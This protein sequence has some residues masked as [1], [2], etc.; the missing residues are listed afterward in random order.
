VSRPSTRRARGGAPRGPSR[1]T[2]S[3]RRPQRRPGHPVRAIILS[4]A[5]PDDTDRRATYRLA[6]G[7][8]RNF[9]VVPKPARRD[10]WRCPSVTNVEHI[11]SLR[12][13]AVTRPA[14]SK[15]RRVRRRPP[16][17]W[18][19]NL[20]YATPW[21]TGHRTE[22]GDRP[23]ARVGHAGESLTPGNVARQ[24]PGTEGPRVRTKQRRRRHV[25]G[26][27]IAVLSPF[28]R[29]SHNRDAYVLRIAGGRFG[30]VLTHRPPHGAEEGPANAQANGR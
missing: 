25:P 24:K 30:P 13:H 12:G 11:R 20:M 14:M 27:W 1:L 7:H 5:S 15:V 28:L 22:H 6:P 16:K 17:L 3:L 26:V 4:T 2:A 10:R 19:I 21:N 8:R 18:T 23:P 9:P 29:Y